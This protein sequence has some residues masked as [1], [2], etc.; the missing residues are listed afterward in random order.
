MD[1]PMLVEETT[2]D[3][4][5]PDAIIA[6]E[7]GK[8]DGTFYTY[9]PHREHLETRF[10][11]L[12]HN[13]R[14][15]I[16]EAMRSTI[17]AMLHHGH[18]SINKI[19]KSAEA[20]GWPGLHREI[21]EKAEICPSCRAAGK[22]LIT[23]LPQSEINRLKTLTEPSQ[24][25]QLDF[26][27]PI[28]AKSRGNIKILVAIDRFNKWPTAQICENTASRTVIEFLIKFCTDNRT[29]RTIR[30]NNGSCFES[31]EIKDYCNCENIK[32]LRCTLNL[33]T[34]TGEQFAQLSHQLELIWRMA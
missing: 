28:N 9:H 13:D 16:L 25:I 31:Q 21:R 23:Q 15:V 5:I 11:L 2:R 8:I 27:D 14:I 29:S 10:G 26:V 17:I 1:L 20:F 30:T 7:A 33:H 22:N 19:D 3:A 4:K 34:G 18:V 24:E 6:L 32:R 12:F